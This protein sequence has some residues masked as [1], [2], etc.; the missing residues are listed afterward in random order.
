MAFCN[1]LMNIWI[2][3]TKK[4]LLCRKLLKRRL[5]VNL[6]W[7]SEPTFVVIACP[8]PNS[9]MVT[10]NWARTT[11]LSLFTCNVQLVTVEN[12]VWR[13]FCIYFHEVTTKK[14]F[15]LCRV[16]CVKFTLYANV[17]SSFWQLYHHLRDEHMSSLPSMILQRFTEYRC[18]LDI[19]LCM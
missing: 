7:T 1:N 8:I 19:L 2:F 17:N 4:N 11:D 12:F 14:I 5:T 3:A 9:S 13:L 18:T 10:F 6:F 15:S 16:S